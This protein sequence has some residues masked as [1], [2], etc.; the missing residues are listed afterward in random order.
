MQKKLIYLNYPDN[1][2]YSS[3]KDKKIMAE[4]RG[5]VAYG[6]TVDEATENLRIELF[7]ADSLFHEIKHSR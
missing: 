3:G 4:F 1:V 6:K 5:I 2:N 7:K